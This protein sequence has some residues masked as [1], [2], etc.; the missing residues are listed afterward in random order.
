MWSPGRSGAGQ[1]HNLEYEYRIDGRAPTVV[2][3]RALRDNGTYALTKTLCD[4]RLRERQS[5]TEAVGGG[6]IVT[7]TLYNSNGG[8][9]RANAKYFALGELSDTPYVP[10]SDTEIPSWTASVCDGMNRSVRQTTWHGDVQAFTAGTE[11]G[12]DYTTTLPAG[13]HPVRTW[14]DTLGR[15]VRVD[16]FTDAERKKFTSTSYQ[17][18]VRGQRVRTT[19]ADGVQWSST[20]DVRG[21]E[22]TATDPDRG[23]SSFTYDNSGRQLTVKDSR[24]VVLETEYDELGRKTAQ[25]RVE[26]EKRTKRASWLYDSVA[27]GL[28]TSSTRYEGTAEYVNEVTGYDAEYLPTGR[29][30]V[31]PE[32]AGAL[33]GTYTYAYTYTPTGKPATTTLPAGGGLTAEQVVNRYTPRASPSPPPAPTG[34]STTPG[35][36]RRAASSRRRPATPVPD[37]DDQLLRPAHG[38]PHAAGQRP[39]GRRPPRERRPVRLRH[40]RQRQEGDGVHGQRGQQ[41]HRHPVLRLRH[42]APAHRGVDVEDADTCAAAPAADQIGGPQ[43]YWHS[44]TFGP[45]GSRLTEKK[46]DPA[47]DTAKDVARRYGYPAP[48]ALRPHTLTSVTTQVGTAAPTTADYVYDA[49]GNTESAPRGRSGRSWTGTPRA[50]SSGSVTRPPGANWPPTSTT[51]T[52][53]A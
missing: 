46:H 52:A 25:Y 43:P 5:Q 47:G 45:T 10:K 44:Y 36:T 49:A 19:D 32:A 15:V 8:I 51:P 33:K 50:G 14:K 37:V 7:D 18:D 48:T 16:H 4:G 30:V 22:L 39:R 24:G 13:R 6:R 21:Q 23:T 31:V 27:L 3:A 1:P 26:G 28:L 2:T 34:T 29:K 12:G 42:P 41:G 9:R 20:Y 40:H 38:P 53:T 11:F 35:T 17:Y